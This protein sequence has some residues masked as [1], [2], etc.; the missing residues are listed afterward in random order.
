MFFPFS[1]VASKCRK[2][3]KPVGPDLPREPPIIPRDEELANSSCIG[4]G[5]FSAVAIQESV[6]FDEVSPFVLRI[7]LPYERSRRPLRA[8]KRVFAANEV[9]IAHP[10]Q[11]VI[12]GLGY[13]REDSEFETAASSNLAR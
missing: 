12:V 9:D 4:V 6:Q 5:Q 10:Q 2:R 3:R 11:E 7:N 1:R 8:N 13:K